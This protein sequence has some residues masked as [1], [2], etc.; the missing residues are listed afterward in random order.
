MTR[1]VEKNVLSLAE[2]S[3]QDFF[4]R[5]AYILIILLATEETSGWFNPYLKSY[6]DNKIMG[7][8]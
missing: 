6:L 4:T 8:T 1:L 2:S 3:R 7:K 5:T